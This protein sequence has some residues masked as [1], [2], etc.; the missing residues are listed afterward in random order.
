[1]KLFFLTLFL[2]TFYHIS[3]SQQRNCASSCSCTISGKIVDAKTNEALEFVSLQIKGT[4]KG[5]STDVNGYFEFKDICE[6]EVDLLISRIGYKSITHHHDIFHNG[7]IVKLAPDNL[8]LESIVVEEEAEV[9]GFKSNPAATINNKDLAQLKSESLGNVLSSITGVSTLS[10]GSNVAKPIIHGL[11]SNRILII[12]NGIR[13]ESQDWGLEHAPEIDASLINN[14]EIIKGASAVKYGPNALGGVILISPPEMELTS[15][16][17]GDVNLKGESNGRAIDGNILLQKGYKTIAWMA[18]VAT[19]YQGDLKAPDYNL[20]NT[21]MR[22]YSGAAGLRFHKKSW[23]VKSSFSYLT[24]ELG[25][26]RGSI[27]GNI[28]DLADA[29]GDDVPDFTD[30]FS[31]QINSPKQQVDHT[32]VKTE[33]LYNFPT[34]RLGV[35]YGLQMNN[36]K[37]F[38]VRRGSN[39]E[40]PS[41]NLELTTHTVD[42]EWLHPVINDWEGTIGGQWLYQDN[43]NI[44]GTN[45]IPF[46]P[47]Y[48]NTRFGMFITETRFLSSNT[49]FDVGLRYDIQFASFRGRD[50]QNNVFRNHQRFNSVSGIVGLTRTL[51]DGGSFR[52]NISTAW[53]PPNIA[54]LYSFGKHQF[55]NEYGFYRYYFD[56]EVLRTDRVLEE[57]EIT[58]ENELGYKLIGSYTYSNDRFQLDASPYLNIIKNYIY[59]AA[60]GISETV[61]GTLPLFIY[62]QTDALFTGLDL[63]FSYFH[64]TRFNSKVSSTFIY[65]KDI[66]NDDVLINIPTNRL[67]YELIYNTKVG[68]YEWSASF[69]VNYI[70]KQYN[71]PR[72]IDPEVFV[73]NPDFNPFIEDDSNFDF[74]PAPQGYTLLNFSS[75][76]SM[77]QW[78]F[79]VRVKN[80]LNTNYRPYTNLLRYFADEQ[81]IN[82]ELGIQLKL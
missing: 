17:H 37:E 46:V 65:T 27:T 4:S 3:E 21:G 74:I 55:T 79:S 61:R 53:R 13:H 31:Y 19:R 80:A 43:N 32:L 9:G 48:N 18:Q 47:N 76:L 8:I 10:T 60:G 33:V 7:L 34:S 22:E 63:T 6:I 36:R 66:G 14:I 24:Q 20:T 16:L 70:F 25:I 56:N 73:D 49:Q 30:D 41:I 44:P 15:H 69:D 39:S 64:S 59:K 81:G 5:T 77:R 28:E 62:K 40:T 1:M 67:S 12:N 35:I 78:V 45:T 82:F 52:L 51:P 2:L 29:I 23:D 54:E 26:L 71:A 38:D 11:H 58:I 42:V 50:S 57:N 68:E 72:V 75:S